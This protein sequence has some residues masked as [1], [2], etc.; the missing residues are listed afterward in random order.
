MACMPCFKYLCTRHVN[1]DCLENRF[2]VIR[3]RGGS[4]KG[5]DPIHIISI[6]IYC[7]IG[8]PKTLMT[9]SAVTISVSPSG[10]RRHAAII[11]GVRI[12]EIS[13]TIERLQ[14]FVEEIHRWCSSR[15]LQLKPSKTEVIWFGTAA[16]LR[17]NKSMDLAL[18]VG[19]DVIIPVNVVRD[20]G[21]SLDQELS[22]KQHIS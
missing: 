6:S 16:N 5:S 2:S 1:Q 15:R 18:H 14:Q 9:L 8:L 12:V 10:N 13:V 3:Q 21:V 22:M 4:M 17:K 20:L 7:S 19:S 11:D